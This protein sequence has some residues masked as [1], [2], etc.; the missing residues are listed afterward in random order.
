VRVPGESVDGR[1]GQK[2][3][4]G[5]GQPLGG[6]PV[7]GHHGGRGPGV[8]LDAELVEVDGGG[9]VQGLERKIVDDQ[10]VQAGK[11]AELCLQGLV[12]AGGAQPSEQLL[13]ADH[14]HGQPPT[15]RDVPESGGQ[16]ALAYP[17]R[18]R[19]FGIVRAMFA[20]VMTFLRSMQRE[21]C[22]AGRSCRGG[23]VRGEVQ[24]SPRGLVRARL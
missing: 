16:V 15:D 10:Q 4:G 18:Y 20:L 24:G 13:R 12:Q 14:L 11:P 1:L 6:L 17:R 5:H 9:G 23:R 3:V 7:T 19:R 2:L 22:G 8:P 21:R